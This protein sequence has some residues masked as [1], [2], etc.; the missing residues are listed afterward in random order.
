MR[1]L[2]DRLCVIGRQQAAVHDAAQQ[3]LAHARLHGGDGWR[4]EPVGGMEDDPSAAAASNTPSI[5][6]QWKCR[7][8]LSVD[9]K[10]WMKATA[11]R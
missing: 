4:I 8:G 2:P 11:P 6:M 3:S 5:T 7:W 9:P 10:R 1:P